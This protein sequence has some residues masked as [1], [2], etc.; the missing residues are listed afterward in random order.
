MS[1]RDIE[2]ALASNLSLYSSHTVSRGKDFVELC[3][4]DVLSSLPK[5]ASGKSEDLVN[6]PV[7]LRSVNFNLPP[8]HEAAERGDS[9]AVSRLLADKNVDVNEK[10][11]GHRAQRTA[12]HR[13]AG[14]GHLSVVQLLIEVIICNSIGYCYLSYTG[15][16]YWVLIDWDRGDFFL[17][18]RTLLVI[19]RAWLLDP[20]WF[21][22][23]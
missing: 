9:K 20:D 15:Q 7:S 2:S 14:Y 11:G 8:L 5:T 3:D 6:P 22:V 13:A 12:L 18:M 17:I 16:N 19:K 4:D 23:A 1:L 10:A 21:K